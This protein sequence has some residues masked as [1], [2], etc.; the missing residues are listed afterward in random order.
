MATAMANRV[1]TKQVVLVA[2]DASRNTADGSGVGSTVVLGL[3]LGASLGRELGTSLGMDDDLAGCKLG[4]SEGMASSS[5]PLV[6]ADSGALVGTKASALLV[7]TEAGAAGTGALS[8]MGATIL[9]SGTASSLERRC[10][11]SGSEWATSLVSSVVDRVT[12]C[13]SDACVKVEQVMT[14]K[15][16]KPATHRPTR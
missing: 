13:K 2:P 3:V 4:S 9:S 14:N 15:I 6:G 7:G 8:D 5:S 11:Y 10:W 1:D 16:V 12:R